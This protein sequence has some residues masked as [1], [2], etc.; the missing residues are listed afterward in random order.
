MSLSLPSWQAQKWVCFAKGGS[1]LSCFDELVWPFQVLSPFQS[2]THSISLKMEPELF[3][4]DS[5]ADE[6]GK[7]DGLLSF[8][9]KNPQLCFS[10]ILEL[11]ICRSVIICNR[12]SD[13]LTERTDRYLKD[14]HIQ[15][16]KNFLSFKLASYWA[17][18]NY[19][20]AS[21]CLKSL[22]LIVSPQSLFPESYHLV[23]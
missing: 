11:D 16:F 20:V 9:R 15:T 8:L 22:L 5:R 1:A 3:H 18:F 23:L 14:Q 12:H 6:K 19:K 21:H 10:Y 17:S 2:C 7:G 4:K 13:Q